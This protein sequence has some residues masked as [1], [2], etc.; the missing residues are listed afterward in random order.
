MNC[1]T[2]M[3]KCEFFE[4]AGK[5]EFHSVVGEAFLRKPKINPA[6]R[7]I[8]QKET[9]SDEQT[10]VNNYRIGK[11]GKPEKATDKKKSEDDE[12]DFPFRRD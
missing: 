6:Q 11:L 3:G 8:D 12:I 5:W 10:L 4:I 7:K 9:I 2:G 1:I